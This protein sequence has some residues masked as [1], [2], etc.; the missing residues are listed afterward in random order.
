MKIVTIAGCNLPS[1]LLAAY[2]I[3]VVPQYMVVDGSRYDTRV[4]IPL[5]QV[6][7]WIQTATT[8][9][10]VLR[11]TVPEF[12]Q[13]YRDVARSDREM[14]VVMTS[15][16]II[17]SYDTSTEAARLVRNTAGLEDLRIDIIDSN[18]LDLGSGLVTLFAALVVHERNR[19]DGMVVL[20]EQ[21]AAQGRTYVFA[22]TIDYLLLGGHAGGRALFDNL[23]ALN[24]ILSL[25]GGQVRAIDRLTKKE[26]PERH[27]IDLA[28]ADLGEGRSVWCAIAH[29]RAPEAAA[30]LAGELRLRFDVRFL[31]VRELQSSIYLNLGD[32]G[33]CLFVYPIDTLDWAPHGIPSA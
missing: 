14:V 5:E 29:G 11:G 13:V 25:V 27:L 21:F 23:F 10:H 12:A 18:S 28:V 3:V 30:R 20:L 1:N 4:G 33:L 31:L 32:G 22:Q 2:D 8:H 24:P 16:L 15:R 19:T 17:G 26:I 9:P 7:R 6:Q